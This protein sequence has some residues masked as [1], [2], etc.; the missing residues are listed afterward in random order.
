[1]RLNSN[2]QKRQCRLT[3][4]RESLARRNTYCRA[5]LCEVITPISCH[6]HTT[7]CQIALF[8]TGTYVAAMLRGTLPIRFRLRC[9]QVAFEH[10]V[11]AQADLRLS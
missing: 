9:L 8:R 4:Q 7:P 6:G 10:L 11:F 1:M 5:M 3:D 2:R